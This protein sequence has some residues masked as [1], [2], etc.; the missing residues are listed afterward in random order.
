VYS[1]PA[2]LVLHE[3]V[4]AARTHNAGS[5]SATAKIER[6]P[7]NAMNSQHKGEEHS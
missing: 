6:Q 3:H 1:A 7:A 2:L 5:G 4:P